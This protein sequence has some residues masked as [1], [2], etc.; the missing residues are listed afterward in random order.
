MRL[1]GAHLVWYGRI[2]GAPRER[3]RRCTVQLT[4][5]YKRGGTLPVSSIS[6]SAIGDRGFSDSDTFVNE[7][8]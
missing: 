4:V 2:D 6:V 8:P 1:E 5:T 3:D 7:L